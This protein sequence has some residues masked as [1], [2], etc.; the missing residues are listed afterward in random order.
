MSNID[1]PKGLCSAVVR[2][3]MEDNDWRL[4]SEGVFVE[5]V[6]ERITPGHTVEPE[7]LRKWCINTY[8]RDALYP[9]C[10]GEQGLQR[11][12]RAFTE[13]AMY[14]HRLAYWRWPQVAEDAVQEALLIIYKKVDRCR[15]PGAFLAFAIQQLRDAAR[16]SMRVETRTLS[17]DD[18]LERDLYGNISADEGVGSMEEE[19]VEK[20]VLYADLRR[21]FVT[22]IEDMRL[23]NP[24]AHRQLDAVWLRYFRELSNEEIATVLETTPEEVSV[25]ISRGLKKLRGDKRLRELAEEILR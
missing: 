23:E 7:Q 12:E 6:L 25:L 11:Q 15:N 5:A 1:D 19:G 3:L 14:L 20:A 13:L 17:L 16:K 4:L 22:L 10:L 2:K 18:L 21:Q 8:C 9:A 24:R